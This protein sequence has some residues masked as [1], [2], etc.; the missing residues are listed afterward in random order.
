[1]NIHISLYRSCCPFQSH[2]VYTHQRHL[3]SDMGG[4]PFV[5]T[6]AHQ[7]LNFSFFRS[8]QMSIFQSIFYSFI[9]FPYFGFVCSIWTFLKLASCPSLAPGASGLYT[10]YFSINFFVP[11]FRFG[12]QFS[13]FPP[14]VCN[15]LPCSAWVSR[16]SLAPGHIKY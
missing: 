1:M 16:P 5:G 12:N 9:Y 15:F 3:L 7:V 13:F 2:S 11:S 4:S 6:W 10:F 8:C 14:F